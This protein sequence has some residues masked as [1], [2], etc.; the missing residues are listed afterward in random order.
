M[1]RKLDDCFHLEK[2]I[3][4]TKKDLESAK[5]IC[6]TMENDIENLDLENKDLKSKLQEMCSIEKELSVAKRNLELF[7]KD[8]DRQSAIIDDKN[9]IIHN[10]LKSSNNQIT[11]S[12]P[13]QTV[14]GFN[15][16]TLNK[17]VLLIGDSI[18]KQTIP[19]LLLPRKY[20]YKVDKHEAYHIDDIPKVINSVTDLNEVF[21][22]VIHCGTNDIGSV[23]SDALVEKLKE[24]LSSVRTQNPDMKILISNI[25]PRGDDHLLDISRQ[26]FNLKLLKEFNNFSVFLFVT[27]QICHQEALLMVNFMA[28]TN[29]T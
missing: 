12:N 17:R 19:D 6:S 22:C 23:S 5:L 2:E 25:T 15:G 28:K 8:Y 9:K 21:T 3:L 24:V 18:I 27:I 10:L 16:Q 14:S 29:Y 4:A 1:Q 11:Q 13:V 20:N 7:E 26:E